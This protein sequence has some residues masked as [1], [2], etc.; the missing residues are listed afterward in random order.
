MPEKTFY[1][2][3]CL[4]HRPEVIKCWGKWWIPCQLQGLPQV[5]QHGARCSP[6]SSA[7][8]QE[9]RD[10]P[11]KMDCTGLVTS[12]LVDIMLCWQSC[13]A[14]NCMRPNDVWGGAGGDSREGGSIFP[15]FLLRMALLPFGITVVCAWGRSPQTLALQCSTQPSTMPA[16]LVLPP[17]CWSQLDKVSMHRLSVH[18]SFIVIQLM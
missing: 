7:L 16:G 3:C 15:V 6:P 9:E 11:L 8:L 4:L 14:L 17:T 5:G 18:Q 1:L 2:C 12:R 10:A 13:K